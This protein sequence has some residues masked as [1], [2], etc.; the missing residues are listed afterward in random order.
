MSTPGERRSTAPAPHLPAL[1]GIR[2]VLVI[3]LL[4]YH[5]GI[6]RLQGAWLTLN[7]FFVLSG[8]LIVRLL[9]AERV[10]TGKL[11]FGAFYARRARRLFP[12]LGALLLTVLV[13]G[14]LFASDAQ[15][16][17]LRWDVLAT[18]GYFMNWRLISQSNQY[19]VQFTEPSMLQ[20]TWSLSVEEQFYLVAPLL[21]LGLT[22][23]LRSR[24]ALVAVFVGLAVVSALWMAYVGV[25]S[26]VARSHT[27]YGTDTRAQSLL[28]G[29]ALGA[30]LAPRAAGDRTPMP[31]F[32]KQ[33]VQYVGWTALAISV[34]GFVVADP[35]TNLMTRGGMFALSIAM[36]AWVWAAADDRIGP[37]QRA[38]AVPP[39]AAL[40]RIS[41]GCYLWHWP[42]GLWL[43]QAM[44]DDG[45][46][47]RVVLGFALTIGIAVLSYQRLELP[48]R[49]EG[50]R[51]IA[52]KLLT[53]RSIAAGCIVAL[54]LGA[55]GVGAK[56]SAGVP[57]T[58]APTRIVPLVAG[59]ASYQKPERAV[60]VAV[61]GDSVADRLAGDYPEANFPRL[62]VVDAAVSGCDLL[63]EP[64]YNPATERM[65]GNLAD[66][67]RAKDAWPQ[68]L[69]KDRPELL[70]I[71]PSTLLTLP[72]RIDGQTRSLGQ[73]RYAAAVEQ[74]LDEVRAG[75]QRTG[76]KV[77]VV[78]MA[79]LD[80]STA[81][82]EFVGAFRKNAPAA[83]SELRKPVHINAILRRWAD[84]NAAP[85]IDLGRAVCPAGAPARPGGVTLFADGVHFD[86]AGAAVIW[87]WLAPQLVRLTG[88]RDG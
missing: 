77:A 30:W 85:V 84:R 25:G 22:A 48:V 21:V 34:I 59:Q 15:R 80:E 26:E 4:T 79:C 7:V 31:R 47:V 81:S 71:F 18:M 44:P 83:L 60:S 17:P 63:D 24:R 2:G 53:A 62:R 10:T 50:L 33:T 37:L 43:A 40:G 29:A 82:P 58:D 49:R 78:T 73:P 1:D 35:Q 6:D 75:A 42:I 69:R 56:A 66:C 38:L 70:L 72:H 55:V 45:A 67:R 36:V 20:H 87:G 64:Y 51:A 52:G 23:W 65:T 32:G 68:Q 8:F 54:A 41:Y 14:F 11:R 57:A 9:V 16:G 19:F 88:S 61:Y 76:T 13:W 3:F 86:P 27:Y 46:A 5:F 74:R 39:L 28:L 12:A